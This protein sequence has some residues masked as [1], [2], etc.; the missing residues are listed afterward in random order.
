M[1]YEEITPADYNEVC[2]IYEAYLNSGDY[3]KDEIRES[4]ENQDFIGLKA[5]DGETVAG[6]CFGSA[7]IRLTYPHPELEAELQAAA[8]DRKVFTF[9]ALAVRPEYRG[10]HISIELLTR[11]AALIRSRGYPVTLSEMWVYPDG[12]IP[13]VPL[14]PHIGKP[15]YETRAEGFYKD[16]AKYGLECPI[17]G[18]NCV[19]NALL[20]LTEV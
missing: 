8:G 4:M 3:I 9:D 12:D 17:C 20:Q 13:V 5:V 6:M 7:G 18:K 15:L 14:L 2:E 19:C 10:Q 11:L 1:R 16:L